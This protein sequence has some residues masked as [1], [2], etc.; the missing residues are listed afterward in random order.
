MGTPSRHCLARSAWEG[1]RSE[2]SLLRSLPC[3]EWLEDCRRK[4]VVI[5]WGRAKME[6]Q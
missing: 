5:N 3:N 2:K 4:T 1:E 6:L